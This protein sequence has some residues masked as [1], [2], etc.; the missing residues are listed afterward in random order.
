MPPITDPSEGLAS[1]QQALARGEL[2]LQ[3]CELDR[4]LHV[5]L[6]RPNGELRLTYVRLD[7]GAVTAFAN[8]SSC[9][10][11]GGRPCFQVGVA[12]PPPLRGQGRARD[13]IRAAIEE[14]RHGLGRNGV[15]DFYVEAI[16]GE[17]NV[18]SRR[19]AEAVISTAPEE[20]KDERSG[21]PVLQY[22]LRVEDRPAAP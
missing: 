5:F 1:F 3:R 10:P 4:D 19:V 20:G 6:D 15:R 13:V 9:E 8:F 16:V 7:G 22:L 21:E 12:V 18:A 11:V 2:H 17:T 14:L